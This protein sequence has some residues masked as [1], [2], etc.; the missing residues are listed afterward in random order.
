[1]D[2]KQLESIADLGATGIILVCLPL[3]LFAV[4]KM[5]VKYLE[6]KREEDRIER[7]KKREEDKEERAYYRKK[8]DEKDEKLEESAKKTEKIVQKFTEILEKE[9]NDVKYGV[10]SLA[11]K[12]IKKE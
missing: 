8:I 5:M 1:M 2:P 11:D 4:Y 6:D 12:I 7:E 3:G 10:K 9:L